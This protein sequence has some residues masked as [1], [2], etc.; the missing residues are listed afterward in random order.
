MVLSLGITQM[1]INLVS[2]IFNCA[3][4]VTI[5]FSKDPNPPI[6]ILFCNLAISDL[7]VSLAGFWIALIFITEPNSTIDG[8]FK[9][10][11][12]YVPY[13]ISILST[14]YNLVSIGIERYLT[15]SGSTKLKCGVTRNQ[16]LSAAFI[17]WVVAIFFGS[18]PLMGWD[19]FKKRGTVSTLYGPFC[20]D[21][22]AF[23]TVPNCV[24]AFV[25]P[26]ITY[27]GIILILRKQKICMLAH[28]QFNGTYKAAEVHVAKTCVF[29]WILALVSYAP[30]FGGVLWDV[31]NTICPENLHS[32]VFVFRNLSAMTITLNS[33]GN[34]II[35]TLKFKDLWKTFVFCKC[36]PNNQISAQAIGNT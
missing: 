31:A 21:Y 10:L 18:L 4:I 5:S 32:S 36:L 16:I 9:V 6:F 22:L 14:I 35:Y 26:L 12:A 7:L 30:F 8:S 1:I 25:L 3:V 20:V 19:C 2:I 29:I 15:V 13:T 34:P 24:L 17:N 27:V 23:I 33:M 11:T 28:G